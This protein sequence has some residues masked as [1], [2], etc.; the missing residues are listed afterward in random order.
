MED[1]HGVANMAAFMKISYDEFYAWMK[2]GLP[3]KHSEGRRK[4]KSFDPD[5]VFQWCVANNKRLPLD[6]GLTKIILVK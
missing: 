1:I 4:S 6:S 3:I 5:K 2:Q